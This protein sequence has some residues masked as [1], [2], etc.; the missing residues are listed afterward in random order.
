MIEKSYESLRISSSCLMVAIL[1]LRSS[2]SWASCA[3]PV[4]ALYAG[5]ID[6]AYVGPNPTISGYVRSNGEAPPGRGLPEV[7]EE[8]FG[9]LQAGRVLVNET[10]L[11]GISLCPHISALKAEAGG[12][13]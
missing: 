3:E 10:R 7:L 6:R 4:E 9:R 12:F 13:R 5:A 2:N 8:A 11:R 1:S